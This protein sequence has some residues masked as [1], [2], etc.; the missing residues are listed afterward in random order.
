MAQAGSFLLI[1]LA[2]D[3][4]GAAI[5]GEMP[6][7][8]RREREREAAV[9]TSLAASGRTAWCCGFGCIAVQRGPPFGLEESSELQ[10]K[11]EGNE[12]EQGCS[13]VEGRKQRYITKI[14]LQTNRWDF[15]GDSFQAGLRGTLHD[16]VQQQQQQQPVVATVVL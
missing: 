8:R 9:R 3:G 13:L 16:R 4:A 14:L 11:E 1:V 10:G 12:E 6:G 5:G 15:S 7:C 2:R